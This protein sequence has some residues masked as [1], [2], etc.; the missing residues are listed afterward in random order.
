MTALPINIFFWLSEIAGWK[1]RAGFLGREWNN[2]SNEARIKKLPYLSAVSA[3]PKVVLLFHT[4][5]LVE[6]NAWFRIF[7]NHLFRIALFLP[8][9]HLFSEYF[10]IIISLILRFN[11]INLGVKYLFRNLNWRQDPTEDILPGNPDAEVDFY[12]F[13]HKFYRIYIY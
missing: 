3:H 4:K 2:L 11:M 8:K 5:N 10:F 6:V 7:S 1:F 9:Q 13:L 12:N